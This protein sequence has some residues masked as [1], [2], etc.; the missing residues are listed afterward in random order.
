MLAGKCNWFGPGSR[1]TI[2]TRDAHVHK[3]HRVNEIYEVKGLNDEDA[4][5]LFCLNAFEKKHVLDRSEERRV[6]K[7][8]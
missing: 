4:L 2:T 7:E 6:G 5:Q 8:C 1:I 3:A